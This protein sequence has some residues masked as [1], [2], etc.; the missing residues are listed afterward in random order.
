MFLFS[1]ELPFWLIPVDQGGIRQN[2]YYRIIDYHEPLETYDLRIVQ[3]EINRKKRLK[4]TACLI[5]L[6]EYNAFSN[7]SPRNFDLSILGLLK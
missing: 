1:I 4:H 5:R 2:M 6:V 7:V 3:V